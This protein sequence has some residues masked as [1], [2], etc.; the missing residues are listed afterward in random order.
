MLK[1][2]TIPESCFPDIHRINLFQIGIC[3][4]PDKN[5]APYS[6]KELP[7]Y[8]EKIT[9]GLSLA[10]KNDWANIVVFP[11]VSISRNILI[12]LM[13]KASDI[14]KAR[15]KD[16]GA[17][18]IC[19][20]MEHLSWDDFNK[21]NISLFSSGFK[22]GDNNQSIESLSVNLFKTIAPND[23]MDAFVNIAILLVFNQSGPEAKGFYFIQPKLCPYS[24]ENETK[25]GI[26][27]RG[28][29]SYLLEIGGVKI[30]TVICYDMIAQDLENKEP[31]VHGLIKEC[32]KQKQGLDYL[33]VPQC[34]DEPTNPNFQ[35]ALFHI[36]SVFQNDSQL[37]RILAPNI[38]NLKINEKV[39]DFGHS[40]IVTNSFYK[41]LPEI[42]LLEQNLPTNP[43][44]PYSG[45]EIK[46]TLPLANAKRLRL[47]APGEWMLHLE[48]PKAKLLRDIGKNPTIPIS[49]HKGKIYKWNNSECIWK[50]KDS[51]EFTH[52]C[53]AYE[54][55][56][57]IK[58]SEL[59]NWI[60]ENLGGKNTYSPAYE[61]FEK[62]VI[63]LPF[64]EKTSVLSSLEKGNDIWVRGAPAS[65]KTVFGLGIAFDWNAKLSVFFDLATLNGDKDPHIENVKNEI[66]Y[67]CIRGHELLLVLDNIHTWESLA[68]SLLLYVQRLRKSGYQIQALLLGRRRENQLTERNSLADNNNLVPVDLKANEEAF[69]CVAIRLLKKINSDYEM[70]PKIVC[71]WVKECGGDLVVFAV[72]FSPSNPESLDR[73]SISKYVHKRYIVPAEKQLGGKDK[74]MDLCAMS[75]I[76]LD[77][78]DRAV[79]K[80][81]A[82]NIYPDF[83]ENG[84]II[85][86]TKGR[87]PRQCCKLFHPSLGELILKVNENFSEQDFEKIWLSQA[88]KVCLKHPLMLSFIHYRL[89]TGEYNNI[90]DFNKW[91]VAIENSDGLVE[92]ALCR[93]PN[94]ACNALKKGNIKWSW[95]R[96]LDLPLDQGCNLLM[97]QLAQTSV[98]E[99]PIFFNYLKMFEPLAPWETLLSN[100]L[101]DD[102]FKNRVHMNPVDGLVE[103]FCYLDNN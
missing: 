80:E 48:F 97:N 10:L 30:L 15:H 49:A 76:D 57:L 8:F 44:D 60:K 31:I 26:F 39:T 51:D 53:Y 95:E 2:L 21:L 56:D 29:V 12:E 22:Y 90:A 83:I 38:A 27:I 75:A 3:L 9:K 40:W 103:F 67:L 88:I 34:N 20:P 81:S 25:G 102:G 70:K 98:G 85:R 5:H 59:S 17:A 74:F 45:K 82:E 89:Y 99:L 13:N 11:E 65:G 66:E 72:A 92:R 58:L 69:R 73:E 41:E 46:A 6:I 23:Y 19:L 93:L 35:S 33:L 4:S 62:R 84:I 86:N 43:K 78:E 87:N 47:A 7:W 54:Y 42:G 79:W 36:N 100:L 14:V 28:N 94:W 18:V 68:N 16:A 37:F 91:C 52:E 24:G 1:Q 71:K 77:I 63:Q 32:L 96:L 61:E 101:N 64:Q 55:Q 50:E